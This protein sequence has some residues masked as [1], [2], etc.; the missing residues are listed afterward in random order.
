MTSS[1]S[2]QP[3]STNRLTNSYFFYG[4]HPLRVPDHITTSSSAHEI[5]TVANQENHH[6]SLN[7]TNGQNGSLSTSELPTTRSLND[8]LE[9]NNDRDDTSENFQDA[10]E[11]LDDDDDKRKDT[12]NRRR[13]SAKVSDDPTL[14]IIQALKECDQINK[15]FLQNH[16]NEAL[17]KAKAQ[18]HRSLYH[19]LCHSTIT[20]TQAVMTFNN[21]DVEAAIQSLKQTSS[22]AK[23]YEP[24]RPWIPFS[25]SGK[26]APNEYE[27]HAKLVYAEALL[28]RALLTFIQDQGL[29]SFISGAIKIKECHDIFVKLAKQND[30]SK[31]SST[32]SYEHFDSG[33]RMGNGAFNLMISNLPQRVIR[34]LEFVG[35]SGDKDFGIEQL[36]LSANSYGLRAAFSALF[37]LGYHTFVTSVFGK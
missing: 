22:L 24:Y 37:L 16:L 9:C 36:E 13:S 29:F 27:L 28:L 10:V 18:E 1:S 11:S 32:F 4:T 15:L 6:L 2:N 8:L 30:R 23:K 14:D 33:V 31:F 34:Y 7:L 5:S 3:T 21:D 17:R 12:S 35:F 20:Y 26:S 25:L 19:S